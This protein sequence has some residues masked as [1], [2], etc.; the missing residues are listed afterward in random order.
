LVIVSP[1]YDTVN[2]RLFLTYFSPLRVYPHVLTSISSLRSTSLVCRPVSFEFFARSARVFGLSSALSRSISNTFSFPFLSPPQF[3]FRDDKFV[4]R[5]GCRSVDERC[6]LSLRLFVFNFL[7]SLGA[8]FFLISSQSSPSKCLAHFSLSLWSWTTT[9]LPLLAFLNLSVQF[10]GWRPSCMRIPLFFQSSFIF[11]RLF[12]LV[13]P[14]FPIH[15][16]LFHLYPAPLPREEK[17]DFPFPPRLQVDSFVFPP[18]CVP[19]ASLL[20][21]EPFSRNCR[22]WSSLS[23]PVLRLLARSILLPFFPGTDSLTLPYLS[24]WLALPFFKS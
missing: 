1:V 22:V 11:S 17:A 4:C 24:H 15:D 16:F 10:S 8:A 14:H 2:E 7:I 6:F 5:S 20:S 9:S 13:F 19:R 12:V 21:N 18:P 23:N 3:V